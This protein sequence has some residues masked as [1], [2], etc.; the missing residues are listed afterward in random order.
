MPFW[1]FGRPSRE[2]TADEL[3]AELWQVFTNGSPRTLRKFC[4]RHAASLGEHCEEIRR[5][6]EEIRDQPQA[7]QNYVNMLIMIAQDLQQRGDP[8]MMTAFT[9]TAATNPILKWQKL[10]GQLLTMLDEMRNE[11]MESQLR[12]LIDEMSALRGTGKDDALPKLH[13]WLG[14]S[15]FHRARVAEAKEHFEK[16]IGLC[17][18]AN[19]LEGVRIY[20]ESLA[21]CHTYLGDQPSAAN[22]YDERVTLWD[23]RGLKD[24]ATRDRK[25]AAMLRAGLPKCRVVLCKD[26]TF[27][28]Q[29]DFV[30]S[31]DEQNARVEYH[32]WRERPDIPNC[33]MLIERGVA[34]AHNREFSDALEIFEKARQVDPYDP[35]PL[36]QSAMCLIEL[37]ALGQAREYFDE[38]ERLAP[39]WV[40][41]RTLRWL[42]DQAEQGQLPSDAPSI[43]LALESLGALPRE[44][45][46]A[47]R[48]ALERFGDL[49]FIWLQLAQALRDLERR[50][51][52]QQA[53]RSG[54][55][56]AEEPDI[57][58]QLLIQLATTLP[59]GSPERSRAI[60]RIFAIDGNLM[61]QASARWMQVID[62]NSVAAS[63]SDSPP[64]K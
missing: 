39:A 32:Y 24:E 16:A 23:E 42:V 50:D 64:V 41:T 9:G 19:D 30:L 51:E 31:P 17:R 27:F 20:L 57:E 15:L 25:Q 53:L 14:T 58:S 38:V 11:E 47:C 33:R 1:I 44:Q 13:G 2:L 34:L 60:S 22:C 63:S 52:M 54:L 29:D 49:A 35:E 48:A 40:G 6:P 7:I 28:E 3:K 36:F 5:V 45:E 10:G 4:R 55:A 21:K 62:A 18:E 37:G 56:C 8:R 46:Q 12:E 43:C 59:V 61:A 26:G